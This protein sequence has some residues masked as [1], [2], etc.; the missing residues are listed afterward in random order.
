MAVDTSLFHT[1]NQ[2]RDNFENFNDFLVDEETLLVKETIELLYRKVNSSEGVP[3]YNRDNFRETHALGKTENWKEELKEEYGKLMEQYQV[4]R[5]T[6]EARGKHLIV[7]W[8]ISCAS[9]FLCL[10]CLFLVYLFVVIYF[11]IL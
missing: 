6:K 10:V 4:N 9:G 3:K 2:L 7:L 1:K 11:R 8:C 5:M